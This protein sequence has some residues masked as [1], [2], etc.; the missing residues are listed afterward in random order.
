LRR[1]GVIEDPFYATNEHDL[2]WID[3]L[4]WEYETVFDLSEELL[5]MSVLEL[6]FDGLDT[7]ADVTFNGKPIL[8]VNNMFRSW[9]AD[10]KGLAKPSGN[11]LHIRFR[12]PVTEDLPKIERLGYN[13]P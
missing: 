11:R 4:D 1:N 13:L 12:S 2:Q 10:V 8:S 3:K 5:A 9:R 6:V 7:Y